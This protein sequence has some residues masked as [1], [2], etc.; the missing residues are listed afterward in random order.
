MVM[1]SYVNRLLA[2][3]V[4][5]EEEQTRVAALLNVIIWSGI[6]I[7]GLRFL[8]ALTGRGDF[9]VVLTPLLIAVCVVALVLTRYGYIRLAGFLIPTSDLVLPTIAMYYFGGI[10][11]PA[12][13]YYLVAIIFAGIFLGKREAVGF[14]VL[15]LIAGF[16]L[17]RAETSGLV[18]GPTSFITPQSAWAAQ[19]GFC[20]MVAIVMYLTS[21]SITEALTHYRQSNRELQAIRASLEEQ[22]LERTA[23]LAQAR[24][25]ALAAA[26][27][28]SEFLATMSHEIRTPMNGVIGM[29][30]L[31]LDTPLT[32]EQREYAEAVEHSGEAL[33]TIINDILDFSKIEAGKFEL[34]LL[35]FPLQ[36]TVEEMLDLLAPKAFAK[37]LELACVIEPDVPTAVRGDPGRVR[38]VLLNLVGSAVKFTQQG[39]VV[40]EVQR[41]TFNVQAQALNLQTLNPDPETLNSSVLRFAV[42]DTGIGIPLERRERLFQSFSQVDASTTRKYGGTGLGLVICKRLVELMGGEIGVDSEPGQGSTFWF[43]VPFAPPLMPVPPPLQPRTDLGKV[44]VLAVDDIAT[45]RRLLHLYLCSWGMEREEAASGEQTLFRL[46][47]AVQLGRPYEVVLLDYQMPEMD[48]L[49]L[50]AHIKG[51]PALASLKLVL[52]TSVGQRE[53]AR[54]ALNTTIAA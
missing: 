13:N 7:L 3:P 20:V 52:L 25:A 5:A 53:E 44:R 33:L 27:A 17:V 22:V 51:D 10:R 41:S 4:F 18:S 9:A 12:A 24:D 14:A 49:E 35:D 39:E 40:V 8:S 54:Q 2:P 15:C 32:A 45:N 23:Q 29:T 37:G 19:G 36:A 31:L 38:Q 46:H 43:T 47:A 21:R 48:G 34:E 50:A 26:Q 28:K 16:G 11:L 1:L 42:R 6:V 30:G